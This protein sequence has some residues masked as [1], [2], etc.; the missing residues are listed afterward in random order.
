LIVEC[1]KICRESLLYEGKIISS[2]LQESGGSSREPFVRGSLKITFSFF[3]ALS[4]FE[5]L[6][7]FTS[8]SHPA[9][10]LPACGFRVEIEPLH[11]K[12]KSELY[13]ALRVKKTLTQNHV[14]HVADFHS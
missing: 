9:S 11:N 6:Y 7:L 4:G 3:H 8:Y 2:L 14:W 12:K 13:F 1:G 5:A 10:V